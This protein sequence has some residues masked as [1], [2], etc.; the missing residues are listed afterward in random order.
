MSNTNPDSLRV[1]HTDKFSL[2]KIFIDLVI[3]LRS[4]E[5]NTFL[6]EV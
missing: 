3:G 6:F 2:K 5:Q 4:I 1:Q